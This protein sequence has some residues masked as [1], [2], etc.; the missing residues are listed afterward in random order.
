M[1]RNAQLSVEIV[2]YKSVYVQDILVDSVLQ[3]ETSEVNLSVRNCDRVIVKNKN[4][5]FS[6][7]WIL[8]EFDLIQGDVLSEV[9]ICY[10]IRFLFDL[11]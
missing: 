4:E 3:D 9:S 6:R 2:N 11:F 7:D 1:S 5:K 10:N 8:N